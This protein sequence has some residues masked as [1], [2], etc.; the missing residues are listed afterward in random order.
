MVVQTGLHAALKRRLRGV[1]LVALQALAVEGLV[2]VLLWSKLR[3]GQPLAHSIFNESTPLRI[4]HGRVGS[5]ASRSLL[6]HVPPCVHPRR[7]V[8]LIGLRLPLPGWHLRIL[9]PD[10]PLDGLWVRTS[11]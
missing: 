11:D 5:R 2:Q 1:P 7:E 10:C 4:H 6:H 8:A 9:L 3:V